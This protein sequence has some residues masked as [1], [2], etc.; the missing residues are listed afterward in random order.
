MDT[1]QLIHRLKLLQNRLS[2]M[3]KE[4]GN[5]TDPEIV[6]VSEEADRLIVQLL[7]EQMYEHD[8]RKTSKKPKTAA[9]FTDSQ[10]TEEIR[11]E[12][13]TLLLEHP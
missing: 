3:A 2:D 8:K 12:R 10:P 9:L 7:K 4:L 1:N 6:A 5:L 13:S 11:Q